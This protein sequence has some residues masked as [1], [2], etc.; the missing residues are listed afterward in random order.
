MTVS[1]NLDLKGLVN[2]WNLEATRVFLAL[3]FLGSSTV[4][5]AAVN[6][7]VVGS[8]P[9]RGAEKGTDLPR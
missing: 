1:P 4:E 8:N 2:R 7:K 9:T 3:P 5:R 6:R